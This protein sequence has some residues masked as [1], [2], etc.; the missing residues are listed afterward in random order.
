MT[1]AHIVLVSW[2]PDTP[3]EVH[4]KLAELVGR[5]P[6]DIPGVVSVVAGSSVSVEHLEAGYTWGMVVTFVNAAARDAYLPHPAHGPVSELIGKWS[7]SLV[8]FDLA[9]GDS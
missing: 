4:A 8:V 2:R 7:A 6:T 3:P 1:L 5:F 9:P